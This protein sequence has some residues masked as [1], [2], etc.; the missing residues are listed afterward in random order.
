[1]FDLGL[2]IMKNPS[3]RGVPKLIWAAVLSEAVGA[4]PRTCTEPG[5]AAANI[6]A[7]SKGAMPQAASCR[8]SFPGP[9]EEQNALFP[10]HKK[11]F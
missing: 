7:A 1:M 4:P 3:K 9:S 6:T 5:K 2:I 11:D 8:G 10:S